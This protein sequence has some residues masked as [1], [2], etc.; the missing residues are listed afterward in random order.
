MLEFLACHEF[1]VLVDNS[2][3]DLVVSGINL[4]YLCAHNV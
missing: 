2:Y 4:H 1:A 3:C